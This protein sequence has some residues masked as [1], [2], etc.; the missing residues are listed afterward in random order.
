MAKAKKKAPLK[1]LSRNL[2]RGRVMGTLPTFT[3]GR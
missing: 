2:Y 1:I 3:S